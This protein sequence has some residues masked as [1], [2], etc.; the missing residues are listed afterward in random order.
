M[1]VCLLENKSEK[2]VVVSIG[3]NMF[4]GLDQYLYVASIVG[5]AYGD[6]NN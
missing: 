2:C 4:L 5:I 6:K 1:F 3:N